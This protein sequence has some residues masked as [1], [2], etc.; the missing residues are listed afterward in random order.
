MLFGF[1]FAPPPIQTAD[2]YALG[3]SAKASVDVQVLLAITAQEASAKLGRHFLLI[4]GL[5]S[6]FEK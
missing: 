1:E 2:T 6:D 5:Q 3:Y 4:V